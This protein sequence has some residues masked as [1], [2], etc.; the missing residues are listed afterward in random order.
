[1]AGL[2][3]CFLAA[4]ST[5]RQAAFSSQENLDAELKQ[6]LAEARARW[7][8]VKMSDGHFVRFVAERTESPPLPP[9]AV[10]LYLTLGLSLGDPHALDAFE[11]TYVSTID[12]SVA[13]LKLSADSLDELKQQL[14]HHLL[15]GES[16]QPLRIAGYS[17]LGPLAAWLGVTAVRMSLRAQKGDVE[18]LSEDDKLADVAGGEASPELQFLQESYR[19]AFKRAFREALASLDPDE[20]NLLRQH[21][22]DGLTIDELGALYRVHRT[23]CAYRLREAQARLVKRARQAVLALTRMSPSDYESAIHAMQSHFALS[24]RTLFR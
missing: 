5:E 13:R 4:L 24:F 6:L 18:S 2:R 14:R 19:A 9:H 21:Y 3:E 1:M 17:G 12:G 16:N 15:V 23:T 7:P 22:L 20:Q 11:R 8:Q 10:E